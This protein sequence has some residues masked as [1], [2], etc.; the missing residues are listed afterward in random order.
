MQGGRVCVRYW[1]K[2]R[3][4]AVIFF[5]SVNRPEVCRSLRIIDKYVQATVGKFRDGLVTVLDANGIC[6][7]HLHGAHARFS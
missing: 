2:K 3:V 7:V 5:S 6:H 4:L 1:G